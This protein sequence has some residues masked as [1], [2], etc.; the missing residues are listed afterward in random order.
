MNF[1]ITK[2]FELQ[3]GQAALAA[4]LLF[5]SASALAPLLS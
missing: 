4:V 1:S 2:K 5:L 3:N